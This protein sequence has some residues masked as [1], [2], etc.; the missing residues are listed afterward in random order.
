MR[1]I[2]PQL[3]E[4]QRQGK[5]Y[6]LATLVKVDRS[7]PK[8]PGA[9]MAVAEDGTVLGSVSGGCVESALHEEADAVLA[10]GQPKTVSYGISDDEGFTIGLACGGQ[11]HLFVDAPKLPDRLFEE[12]E[13]NRPLAMATIVS[14]PAAGGR[15]VLW[16]EA[17]TSAPGNGPLPVTPDSPA[18]TGFGD[19]ALRSA[20]ANDAADLLTRQ[21]STLKSYPQGDVFIQT[22]ALPAEMY[23]FGAADFSAALASMGKFLGF[24]VT[25]IDPR[26]VFATRERFPAADEIAIEWPDKFLAKAPIGPSTA[27]C[28]LTHDAKFDVPALLQALKTDAGYIGAMGAKRTNEERFR[29][30]REAGCTEEQLARIKAPIG[31][32][33]GGRSPE[34]TAVSVAAQIIAWRSGKL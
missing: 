9:V 17:L 19:E 14:G 22:F 23:I 27:I 33:I 2:A 3:R 18:S 30:L 24:H 21:A 31:L 5:R 28:V 13:A 20:V 7:A 4:W 1:D 29:K 15:L 8:P 32:D 16:P 12:I 34:E 11:L 25:V 26:T 10:S 6:A